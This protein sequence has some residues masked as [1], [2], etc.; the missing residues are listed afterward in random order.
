MNIMNIAKNGR[1]NNRT[2]RLRK[3][4]ITLKAVLFKEYQC[5]FVGVPVVDEFVPE[6]VLFSLLP[7]FCG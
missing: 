1:I 5:Y 2:E 3:W 6:V 4:K 7:A